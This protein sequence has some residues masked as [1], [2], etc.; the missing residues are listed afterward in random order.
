[1]AY[2]VVNPF[3]TRV[4]NASS[5]SSN[6]MMSVAVPA[7]AKLMGA[8]Y[9][10]TPLQTHTAV[11]TAD[12]TV[13]GSTAAGMTGITVSTSTGN[14]S[15]NLGIPTSTVFLNAGDVLATVLSSCVGGNTS[16]VL[17]EF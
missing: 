6:T 17:R 2:P 13:N 7:R 14:S 15:T 10:T 1:M 12:I 4:L 5:S 3:K 8:F 16:F 11:G 9:A